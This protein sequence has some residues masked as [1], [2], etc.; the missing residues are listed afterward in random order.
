[1]MVFWKARLAVLAAPKTG[2][3]ALQ[4][5]L[6]DKADIVFRHPTGAKHMRVQK[7]RRKLLPLIDP[8]SQHG[9]QTMAVVRAPVD[10]LGSWYRYRQ[11]PALDGRPNSTRGISFDAFVEAYLA[12]NPPPYAAVGSQARFTGFGG[13]TAAVDHLFDYADFPACIAFLAQRLGIP[14]SMPAVANASGGV[15]P[16]LSPAVLEQLQNQRP[17]EFAL[18]QLVRAR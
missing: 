6:G 5:A 2:T 18:Y 13:G 16:Q 11:R 15:A 12:K 17:E 3:H 7:F 9:L 14:L 8:S 4:N 1:M 10:W